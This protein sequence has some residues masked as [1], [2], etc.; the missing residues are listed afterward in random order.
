MDN[1]SL[2]VSQFIHSAFRSFKF[3]T[4]TFI[5]CSRS[6]GSE[7]R[8]SKKAK[9]SRW[10]KLPTFLI[11]WATMMRW[12]FSQRRSHQRQLL[13]RL[14]I[15]RK[16][17]TALNLT[18][19]E[20]KHLQCFDRALPDLSVSC[21]RCMVFSILRRSS[22]LDDLSFDSVKVFRPSHRPAQS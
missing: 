12:T 2:F 8:D 7:Q 5:R 20:M 18:H 9:P 13:P 19:F 16:Q 6:N 1:M 17:V 10:S 3:G 21:F 14:R 11:C 22:V 4:P 15:S